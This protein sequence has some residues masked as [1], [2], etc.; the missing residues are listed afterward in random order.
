MQHN[1]N[2]IKKIVPLCLAVIIII[3]CKKPP[4]APETP[5]VNLQTKAILVLNEGLFQMNN[6]SLTYYSVTDSTA[7][8]DFFEGQ[9]NRKLGDTG[10][11]MAIYGNKIYVILTTSSQIEVLDAQSG[12]S[13]RQIPLFNQQQARQPRY[14]DFYQNKAYVCSFDGTVAVIDTV[15]LTVEKFIPVGRNPDGIKI[16]N[17]KIY[18]SNSG[19]LNFPNYDNT[20]SVIDPI[21]QTE[22]KRITVEINPYKMDADSYGDLY[23]ISRGNYGNIK[24]C[25]QIIDTHMDTLKYT[26]PGIE[27]Q[28]LT[29]SG[30]TAYLYHYDF[31]SQRSNFMLINVKTEQIISSNISS[32]TAE[33]QTPYGISIDSPTGHIYIT[34]ARGFINQGRVVCF[35]VSGNKM[36]EFPTG[37]NPNSIIFLR[38]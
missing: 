34:D 22:I 16:V 26:F 12:I 23:V 29:I 28:N 4:I 18:A 33:I 9:N 5:D 35:S 10:N 20:I 1:R 3:S 30:D 2:F 19:G 11:H 32:I 15:S 8:T 37:L 14:I 27:A 24:S 6:S 13:I 38:N 21:S 17:H 36:F 31:N 7:V 25:L